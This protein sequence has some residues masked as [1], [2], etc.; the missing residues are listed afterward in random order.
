M[1]RVGRIGPVIR[2]IYPDHRVQEVWAIDLEQA[3]PEH[4]PLVI[5]ASVVM[6]IHAD[7]TITSALRRERIRA[8][9]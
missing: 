1:G 2:W 7:G 4:E 8:D 6:T 5:H 3:R 9:D